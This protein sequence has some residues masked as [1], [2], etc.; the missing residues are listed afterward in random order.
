MSD[1]L[2]EITRAFDPIPVT[3]ADVDRRIAQLK[4]FTDQGGKIDR[5]M[6]PS[7]KPAL[8]DFLF[9]DRGDLWVEPIVAD[10]ALS[11][12]VFDLFD[13]RGRYLGRLR[14]PFSLTTYPKPVIRDDRI[15]GVTANDLGIEFVV[16]ARIERP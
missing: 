3:S 10:S 7:V 15:Y 14:L 11:G 5:G 9:D 1:T 8:G 16:I 12:R 6:I 2:Q 13:P 4:W